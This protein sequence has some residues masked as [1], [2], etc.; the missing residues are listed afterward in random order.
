MKDLFAA[1]T[2]ALIGLAFASG[3][4][5]CSPPAPLSTVSGP[6]GSQ[7]PY[8]E[9]TYYAFLGKVVGYKR[10]AAGDPALSI[11]VLDAWTNRQVVGETVTIG[12]AR[13]QG[14]G[15]RKPMGER[16]HPASYPIGTR[17]R[18]VSKE[19]TMFTWDV[20]NGILV[21]GRSVIEPAYPVNESLL[22]TGFPGL[23]DDARQVAE[24]LASCTHFSGEINGDGSTR[25]QEVFAAMTELRCDTIAH[26]AAA[27]REKYANNKAVQN[28]LA[29]AELL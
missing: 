16:F 25:D 9:P 15:L 19:D 12:V 6:G 29:A 18:V 8:Q 11:V 7:I 20:E 23:P 13:W 26:D 22:V 24:R 5:A 17:V 14:C 21:L 4:L 28:A 10:N 2:H 27:I 1:I 3:A